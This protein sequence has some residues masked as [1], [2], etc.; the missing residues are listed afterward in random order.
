MH[1]RTYPNY[2]GIGAV[3]AS[4]SLGALMRGGQNK[5]VARKG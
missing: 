4:S 3:S 5:H 1:T 2:T